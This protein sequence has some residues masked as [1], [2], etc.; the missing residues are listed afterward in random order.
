MKDYSVDNTYIKDEFID[1]LNSALIRT[2][3]YVPLSSTLKVADI[4][5][6]MGW[7]LVKED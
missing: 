5:I 6:S 3:D 2:F 1:N 7:K 4:L